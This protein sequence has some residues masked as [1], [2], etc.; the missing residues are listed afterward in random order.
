MQKETATNEVK[1]LT[2]ANSSFLM[3]KGQSK[4]NGFNK[5]MT[6]S[7]KP[8]SSKRTGLRRGNR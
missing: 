3:K 6:A 1:K 2:V 5:W 4:G 7:S 8:L